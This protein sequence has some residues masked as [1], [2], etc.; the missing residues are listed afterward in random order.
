M[1]IAD[2]YAKG[3][4]P[5]AGGGAPDITDQLQQQRAYHRRIL[6]QR[7]LGLWWYRILLIIVAVLVGTIGG[8]VIANISQAYMGQAALTIV[9]ISAGGFVG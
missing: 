7:T 8:L 5:P 2:K 9:K 6:W 1:Q 4:F 3:A